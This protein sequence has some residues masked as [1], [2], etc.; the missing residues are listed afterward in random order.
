[1]FKNVASQKI[2]VYAVDAST[3]LP[4][5]GD[6]ANIT[7]YVSKDDGSV[8]ALGDTSATEADATNAKGDYLFDVTQTETNADKL[9]F[10]GKSSTSN[11]VIVPQTIYTIPASWTIPIVTLV[12]GL[13]AGV[14]NAAAIAD[15]AIDSATF[16]ADTGLQSILSGTAQAGA[17]TSI[18]LPAGASATTDYYKYATIVLTGGTGA[19]QYRII[20]SYNGSTKVAT[21]VPA[22]ATNPDVTTTFAILPRGIADV[23]MFGGGAGSFSNGVPGVNVTQL[24]GASTAGTGTRVEDAFIAFFNVAAPVLTAASVN[25][26]GDNYTRLGAP[27]GAS[28]A[29]DLAE[30]EAETDGIAA[31]PTSNPTAAAIATAVWTDTTAADFTVALSV[32]K[33]VMNGVTLGTGLTVA[34]LTNAPTAGD[35]TATMKASVQ[36][37]ADAAITANVLVLEIEAETDDIAAIKAKTDNLPA[38]PA[39]ASDCLTAAGVRTAVGLATASLDTQLAAIQADSPNKITKNTA[40]AAFEFPMISSSDHFTPTTG[41]TVTA[42]RSIDGAAFAACANAV[43]EVGNGVY[44]INLAATDL[45]G[46]MITLRFAATGADP[47]LVGIAT[48]P[49]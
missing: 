46:D 8:T 12:N 22:W 9:R 32:G 28:I 20:R 41:L 42:T 37:A 24:N 18:T 38:S 23:E 48:Q 39:A 5:T 30:I 31:I 19:G 11:V 43:A 17:S 45:N 4:K 47:T 21:T 25:Q 27:A 36:T 1:V 2:T 6:A 13:A 29:A 3:G 33:S 16:A 35:L 7:V 10:T 15:N 49:T 44:K 40:L 34:N 26:T 14:V